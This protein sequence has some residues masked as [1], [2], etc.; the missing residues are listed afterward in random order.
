MRNPIKAPPAVRA[1]AGLLS[2]ALLL[3][4]VAAGAVTLPSGARARSHPSALAGKAQERLL[5]GALW[6]AQPQQTSLQTHAD[7]VD[8]SPSH[9]M[10]G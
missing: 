2:A 8:I 1:L 4:P 6:A 3:G 7:P 9:W 10:A 5:E